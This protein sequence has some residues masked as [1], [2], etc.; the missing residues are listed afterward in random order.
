MAKRNFGS[1]E[2]L[3]SGRWR[4]Y[5]I[6]PGTVIDRI[7]PGRSFRT[8]NEAELWLSEERVAHERGTW[9]SREEIQRE[10]DRQQQS[11]LGRFVESWWS[12][13]PPWQPSEQRAQQNRF[14]NHVKPY[15][16]DVPLTEIDAAMI[17][18]WLSKLQTKP[19]GKEKPQPAS[20]SLRKKC[21]E[22]MRR[23]LNEATDREMI[24]FNPMANRK[25]LQR[26]TKPQPG[27]ERGGRA[28]R[29]WTPREIRALIDEVPPHTRALFTLL[30]VCGLRSSEV[31][32]LTPAD[33]DLKKG[34]LSITHVV[35]QDGSNLTYRKGTKT[36]AG[37]RIIP[38]APEVVE[39]VKDHCRTHG[40]VARTQFLFPSVENPERCIPANTIRE[41]SQRASKRLAYDG[42]IRPH[43]LRHA[44]YTYSQRIPGVTLMDTKT[45]FGHERSSDISDVY[46][47]TDQAQQELIARGLAHLIL[48]ADNGNLI[49]LRKA[50]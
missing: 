48:D 27:E 35:T 2:K 44:S 29:L 13:T 31:R 1:V 16:E 50:E 25:Y 26:L 33:F 23:I 17:E 20:V 21:Y 6:R 47:H 49:P 28:T 10:K 18:N 30:A 11:T 37:Q 3:P 7:K 32:P 4:A 45:Y 46:S 24:P 9:R 15:F 12:T 8:K 41:Q 22:L 5:Y 43:E 38:L 40:I 42:Y 39:I 36:A 34:L 14:D 19:R